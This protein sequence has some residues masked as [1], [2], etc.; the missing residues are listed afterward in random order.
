[1]NDTTAEA[2]PYLWTDAVPYFAA[3]L[4]LL[5]SQTGARTADADKMMQRYTEFVERA[6]RAATG[7]VLPWQYQGQPVP[8]GLNTPAAPSAR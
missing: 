8:G 1:V 2:I 5:S 7:D 6:K 3:Y 4:A